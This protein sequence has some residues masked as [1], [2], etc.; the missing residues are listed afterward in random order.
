MASDPTFRNYKHAQAQQYASA[1]GAYPPVLYEHI[2][3]EHAA[4]GGAFGFV[5]DVGCGPGTATRDLAPAFE[6]A[7][8]VDGGEAMIDVARTRGGETRV[9]EKIRYEVCEAERMAGLPG[10]PLGAVDLITVA[11]AAHWFDMAS[12]WAQAAQLLRPHG[13]VAI[14]TKGVYYPHPAMPYAPKVKAINEALGRVIE[15]YAQPGN[16]IADAMYDD[17]ELPWA[18]GASPPAFPEDQFRRFDWDRGGVLSDGEDFFGGSRECPVEVFVQALGSV[19]AVTRWREAHPSLVG[20]ERDCVVEAAR[21]LRHVLGEKG[22]MRIEGPTALLMFKR[23]P[24]E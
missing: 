7:M 21:Q 3:A 1:R 19:S 2:F 5:L 9:G 20:T 8:G 10:V 15:P 12:F 14:W 16:R 17:L 4:S 23:G 24:G 6:H 22:T 18:V 11:T 13:T